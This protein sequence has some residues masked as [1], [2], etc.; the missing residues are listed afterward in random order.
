MLQLDIKAAQTEPVMLNQCKPNNKNVDNAAILEDI[1][2]RGDIA[3]FG[4]HVYYFNR[5][6]DPAILNKLRYVRMVGTVGDNTYQ[7]KEATKD[8]RK[9]TTLYFLNCKSGDIC[10]HFPMTELPGNSNSLLGPFIIED[11]TLRCDDPG[12]LLKFGTKDFI[13]NGGPLFRNLKL[14]NVTLS[15]D[16]L[17]AKDIVHGTYDS[18][19]LDRSIEKNFALDIY[20]GYDIYVDNLIVRGGY[21]G[22]RVDKSDFAHW[23]GVHCAH[24]AYSILVDGKSS[25]AGNFDQTFL[26]GS[27]LCSIILSHGN[28]TNSRMENGYAYYNSGEYLLKEVTWSISKNS[29][30][31]QVAGLLNKT[32]YDFIE[33][34]L[35]IKIIDEKTNRSYWLEVTDIQADKIYFN[36]RFGFSNF[37]RDVNGK[38]IF[39]YFGFCFGLKPGF[40]GG[41]YNSS[42]AFNSKL[43]NLPLGFVSSDNGN[44][45]MISN[46]LNESVSN[47]STTNQII[48]I[49]HSAGTQWNMRPTLYYEGQ[50]GLVAPFK[51]SFTHIQGSRGYDPNWTIGSIDSQPE[52]SVLNK[53]WVFYPGYGIGAENSHGKYIEVL[54][55]NGRLVEDWSY[56][57]AVC[58]RNCYL[59]NFYPESDNITMRYTIYAKSLD[60]TSTFR[61]CEKLYDKWKNNIIAVTLSNEWSKISG[62][63]TTTCANN[64]HYNLAFETPRNI[65]CE[66]IVFERIYKGE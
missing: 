11:I 38:G 52:K 3:Y 60:S 35:P 27:S 16:G 41:I 4:P 25:V 49:G 53:K 57:P 8:S 36:N 28:I 46:L 30:Y 13:N 34:G 18:Y 56:L 21:Y 20:N 40:I 17:A 64:P 51:S 50:F 47:M 5:P 10:M 66:K 7:L 58:G 62:E 65:L 63:F 6:L 29:N 14:H 31:I 33:P 42:I 22:I 43:P 1:L 37:A 19:Y 54:W 61:I 15:I 39:S 23:N 26:E 45:C 48:N 24:Q 9:S 44:N 59:D 2:S 12:S 55:H 32:I